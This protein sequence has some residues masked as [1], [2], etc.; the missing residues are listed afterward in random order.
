MQLARRSHT[1]GDKTRYV[2]DYSQWLDRG[3]TVVGAAVTSTS[4]TCTVSGVAF[5]A[6]EIVFFINGGVLSETLTLAVAMTDSRT[7]IKHDTIAV[8]VIA[9]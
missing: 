5:T 3:V 1:V 9:P 2:I 8:F 4:S 6:T 7:E